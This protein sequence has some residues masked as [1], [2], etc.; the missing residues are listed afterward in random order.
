MSLSENGDDV[1]KRRQRYLQRLRELGIPLN[2]ER[3]PTDEEIT[4]LFNDPVLLEN[5]YFTAEETR[6]CV[7][8]VMGAIHRGEKPKILPLDPP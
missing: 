8:R 5:P 2:Q 4:L 1:E 6:G 3:M 7:D